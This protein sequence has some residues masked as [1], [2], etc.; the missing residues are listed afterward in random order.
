MRSSA[1]QAGTAPVGSLRVNTDGACEREWWPHVDYF[2]NSCVHLYPGITE[3]P[4]YRS[5][6]SLRAGV[7]A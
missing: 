7:V 6:A 5:E 1:V 4:G 3:A 2:F